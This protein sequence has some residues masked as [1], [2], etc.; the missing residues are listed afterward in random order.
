M[1]KRFEA[2]L[3]IG[4]K[5]IS[6][7]EINIKSRDAVPALVL[8][9]KRIFVTS[10]YNERIFSILERKILIGKK[11]TGRKGMD[12]W[13][14]FV[15]AQFRLGLRLS[16]DR[17]HHM[18]N[19]DSLLRQLMGIE[20]ESGFEKIEIEYQNII[21]NVSLLDDKTLEEINKIIVEF[22]HDVFKKKDL[23]ALR[24]K[25]DSFVVKSNVHF[26]TDYNLL[27]DSARKCLDTVNYFIKKYPN[28]PGWRKISDWYR[29]MKNRMRTLGQSKRT[30]GKS[31]EERTKTAAEKYI[32]KAE[33]LLKKL[34]DSKN[35]IIA[36]DTQDIIYIMELDRFIELMRK[37]IDLV[38]RRIIKGEII[39]HEEKM[40]SI[41]EDYTEWI[42]KGKLNPSFELGKKVAITTDQF[43][44]IIDYNIMN[45]L[46][47]SEIVIPIFE[48]LIRKYR[49]F[50]WS[51]DKGGWHKDNKYALEKEIEKVIM[52]KK[53]KCNKQEKEEEHT[54]LFIKL[55]HKHSAIESNINELEHRG[56]DRCPDRSYEHFKRYIGL[57]VIAYNL[58]RIGKRIIKDMLLEE[59]KQKH[60]HPRVA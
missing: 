22:G 38:D 8:S 41:F 40:F 59:S 53:G 35:S 50:S 20:S 13:Q 47:D 18:A 36:K 4:R 44:L 28:T 5:K 31:N 42:C 29:E 25:T 52:P 46:A 33:V 17:L 60:R 27:W 3:S 56:L 51:Y 43:H 19:Y 21:D 37:H 10:E 11:K 2:Q 6:D 12:L 32:I 1:R 58:H 15:L 45:H 34:V 7:I 49:I 39:P 54:P 23:E 55:R 48:R 14:I 30:G 24:L 9:L 26:P 16:Y 57:G